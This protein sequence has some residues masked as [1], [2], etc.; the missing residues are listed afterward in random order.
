M[1]AIETAKAAVIA[2]NDKNW[3]RVKEVVVEKRIRRE[4]HRT[5]D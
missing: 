5:A 1:N 2:Y 3:D 4:G